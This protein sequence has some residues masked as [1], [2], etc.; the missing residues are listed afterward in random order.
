MPESVPTPIPLASLPEASPCR[1]AVA[2]RRPLAPAYISAVA[3]RVGSAAC[4]GVPD[5]GPRRRPR[6]RRPPVPAAPGRADAPGRPSRARPAPGAGRSSL[7]CRTLRVYFVKPSKYDD[8]GRV[9]HFWRACCRTTRSPCSRALNDA[10]NRAARRRRRLRRDGHLG[11][12][13]RRSGRARDDPRHPG[14]GARGRRRGAD[15]ARRRADEPVSARP[16]PGAPV[17]TRRASPCSSAAST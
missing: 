17:P 3:K 2:A 15:R 8:R 11:R 10:Y 14:E 1:L 5:A 7:V 9:A 6:R 12:A 13:G 16:R 4:P